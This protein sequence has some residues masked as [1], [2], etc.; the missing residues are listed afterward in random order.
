MAMRGARRQEKIRVISVHQAW[1]AFVSLLVG[2]S[3]NGDLLAL[4]LLIYHV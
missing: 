4:A 3:V 1:D 2:K